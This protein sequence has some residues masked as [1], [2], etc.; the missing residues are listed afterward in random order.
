MTTTT[1]P[2]NHT[3][4][5]FLKSAGWA[6]ADVYPMAGDAS[7]RHYMR[8]AQPAK[9]AMLMVCPNA[10]DTIICTPDMTEDT[11]LQHGWNAMA[12][13]SGNKVQAFVA[14]STWLRNHGIST[15]EIYFADVD[16]GL[17]LV[18]DFG[19]NLL[20]NAIEKHQNQGELYDIAADA[21]E[22][23][24]LLD[25]PDVMAGHG[26]HWPMLT[27]DDVA[28]RAGADLFL[29]WMPKLI[30]SDAFDHDA[31]DAW[32]ALW[33]PLI[34]LITTRKPV[35]TLRDYH[36]ENMIWLPKREGVKRMGMLDFQDAVMGHP[37]WD[38]VMLIEDVR[39]DV[40][41]DTYTRLRNRWFKKYDDR[42]AQEF[43]CVGAIN[44]TR[45][46]G[47]FA[48]LAVRDQK[49]RYLDFMPR[50][51]QVLD[52]HLEDQTLAPLQTWLNTHAKGVR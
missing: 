19:D 5:S 23:I 34:T 36:A 42:F 52:Q 37:A 27:Y 29:T 25:T 17:I 9:T 11:R 7:S 38:L 46:L 31:V 8:V 30:G 4:Q 32:H 6:Q 1:A 2:I 47:I 45:I 20:A 21:L 16:A 40:D 13:L 22:H 49:T 15:P 12:R 43:A 24:Q 3:I 50:V 48:R 26:Q 10:K 51:W 28:L 41:E 44:A 35:L 14:I 39:R 18:E 33:Q